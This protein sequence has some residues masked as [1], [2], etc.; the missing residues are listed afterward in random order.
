MI[1]YI[2]Y[3]APIEEEEPPKSSWE[4]KY[5]QGLFLGVFTALGLAVAIVSIIKIRK[6][7]GSTGRYGYSG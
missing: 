2:H 7:F 1:G 5:L 4:Q 3:E 6:K